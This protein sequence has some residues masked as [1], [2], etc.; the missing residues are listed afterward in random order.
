MAVGGK[1]KGNEGKQHNS[2]SEGEGSDAEDNGPKT[3]KVIDLRGFVAFMK[4]LT[5][6][7]AQNHGDAI[8]LQYA[9]AV[10]CFKAVQHQMKLRTLHFPE[11][12]QVIHQFLHRGPQMLSHQH[13]K[14]TAEVLEITH[15]IAR[16]VPNLGDPLAEVKRVFS[17]LFETIFEAFIF[18]DV[19]GDWTVT[20]N[21]FVQYCKMLQLPLTPADLEIAMSDQCH[22]EELDSMSFVRCFR[23]YPLVEKPKYWVSGYT[24]MPRENKLYQVFSWL[25][26]GCRAEGVLDLIQDQEGTLRSAFAVESQILRE[27]EEAPSDNGE[28]EDGGGGRGGVSFSRARHATKLMPLIEAESPTDPSPPKISGDKGGGRENKFSSEKTKVVADSAERS[29]TF[30]AFVDFLK[31]VDL[32]PIHLHRPAGKMKADLSSA[33]FGEALRVFRSVLGTEKKLEW[34]EFMECMHLLLTSKS[35]LRELG[36]TELQLLC[37]RRSLSRYAPSADAPLEDLKDALSVRFDDSVDAFVFFDI[38]GDWSVTQA[39]M[40][41]MIK[42]LNVP[43]SKPDV[44]S[45]LQALFIASHGGG[46]NSLEFVR[47]LKWTKDDVRKIKEVFDLNTNE[48]RLFNDFKRWCDISNPQSLLASDLTASPATSTPMAG[49]PS[50]RRR[51]VVRE[52]ESPRRMVAVA[53]GG[54]CQPNTM[55]APEAIS[56]LNT[57]MQLPVHDASLEPEE[58]DVTCGARMPFEGFEGFLRAI[59]LLKNGGIEEDHLE[60]ARKAFDTV[61]WAGD[62][63]NTISWVEFKHVLHVYLLNIPVWL[64]PRLERVTAD[65]RQKRMLLHDKL[66]TFHDPIAQFSALLA[67]RFDSVFEAFVFFDM[68]GDWQVTNKEMHEMLPHLELN[69]TTSDLD[70]TIAKIMR[71][72]NFREEIFVDPKQFAKNLAWHPKPGTAPGL[73]RALDQ[74]KEKRADVVE[75]A[76]NLAKSG[77]LGRDEEGIL[78]IRPED[79]VIVANLQKQILEIQTLQRDFKRIKTFFGIPFDGRLAMSENDVQRRKDVARHDL[80]ARELQLSD[81]GLSVLLDRAR[82]RRAA[83]VTDAVQRSQD[84]MYARKLKGFKTGAVVPPPAE[85]LLKWVG[86]N[87]RVELA[88]LVQKVNS[89]KAAILRFKLHGNKVFD[90][91]VADMAMSTRERVKRQDL[92]AHNREMRRLAIEGEHQLILDGLDE[93]KLRR[94]A[95]SDEA[96]KRADSLQH[97]EW[98]NI[99]FPSQSVKQAL[100]WF[101]DIARARVLGDDFKKPAKHSPAQMP[102]GSGACI[103]HAP[104]IMRAASFGRVVSSSRWGAMTATRICA[105]PVLLIAALEYR[106]VT[107]YDAWCFFDPDA[108]WDVSTANFRKKAALLQ[109]AEEPCDIEG[110]IRKLDP[111]GLNVVGP[112]DFINVLKWHELGGGMGDLRASFDAAAA[113]RLFAA[114]VALRRSRDPAHRRVPA[115]TMTVAE[116][117]QAEDSR[118]RREK[119]RKLLAQ[120]SAKQARMKELLGP[121]QMIKDYARQRDCKGLLELETQRLRLSCAVDAMHVAALQP[122]LNVEAAELSYSFYQ[123]V[124][125]H[126]NLAQ[127]ERYPAAAMIQRSLRAV[128]AW[129]CNAQ[130]QQ[131]KI[132]NATVWGFGRGETREKVVEALQH[133]ACECG[134]GVRGDVELCSDVGNAEV[135]CNAL[136]HTTT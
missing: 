84:D 119:S 60:L 132:A 31:V 65:A 63:E 110:V 115:P 11:C 13:S 103:T 23:W 38:Q 10:Q 85:V 41:N 69:M 101:E 29:M 54:A 93:A 40:L 100:R 72:K 26:A 91:R 107:I 78:A 127:Q 82:L 125:A 83:I 67:T 128:T 94:R 59:K 8:P 104:S 95:I 116:E 71:E 6:I 109:L 73:R 118:L 134:Y 24:V 39:E 89:I 135:P 55:S 129:R 108:S 32:I 74:A 33:E 15:K 42:R 130:L 43:L 19:S 96:L 121:P 30:Q 76:V 22:L 92:F 123:R 136:R 120:N 56:R 131:L 81:R 9:V 102:L 86:K 18:F 16:M 117:V 7:P 44:D 68:D 34:P 87:D 25:A 57:G 106:F 70:I 47:R 45:A 64:Q 50:S 20:K 48:V 114:P 133:A 126:Y 62:T 80:K 97:R 61:N 3:E 4:S 28:G 111:T 79:E 52:V 12:K 37:M 2:A 21:E 98:A 124:S 51:S 113:R 122:V 49:T 99:P 75:R 58:R 105:A 77:Q 5:L 1:E 90:V 36:D 66:V 14:K 53:S 112:L 35:L 27:E 46:I 17:Q 88:A